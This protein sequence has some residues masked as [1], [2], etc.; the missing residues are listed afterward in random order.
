MKTLKLFT[1]KTC[2]KCPAAKELVMTNL[3]AI[4]EKASIHYL[5]IDTKEGIVEAALLSVRATPS[6]IITERIGEGENREDVEVVG[7]RVD[8]PNKEELL[9]AL[10]I[11]AGLNL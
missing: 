5:D 8:M 3:T 9:A 10:E 2:P 4:L 6:I 11:L 7:W 1:S